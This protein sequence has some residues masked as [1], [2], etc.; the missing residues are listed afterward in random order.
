MTRIALFAAVSSLL[1]CGV[2]P[3]GNWYEESFYLLHEDHHTSGGREVGRDADLRETSRLVA[4]SRPDVIQIHAKGIPGWTT[5]PTAVGHAPPK[6]VGDVLGIW[7]DCARQGGY[8]FS[9]YFNLGRD[10]EIMTR[11]PE[12]NRVRAD[13]KPWDRALCYHSG[14]AEGY[15]WPMIREIIEGYRPDGFWFDGSCF[16]VRVC[17]CPKCRQAMPRDRQRCPHCGADIK[18]EVAKGG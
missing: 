7:R 13:G 2:A 14:V 17:Y 9:V 16:T 15:L 11:R 18:G 4:L 1:C 5:Y 12:W 10:G 3:A 8:R 6:L